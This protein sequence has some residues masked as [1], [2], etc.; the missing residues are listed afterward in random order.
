[1]KNKPISQIA[2]VIHDQS[3]VDNNNTNLVNVSVR[4]STKIA[5]MLELV[6]MIAG[7][8]ISTMFTDEISAKLADHVRSTSK[9]HNQIINALKEI[10]KER[11]FVPTGSA[12]D[13]LIKNGNLKIS[14]K[15]TKGFECFEGLEDYWYSYKR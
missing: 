3:L 4:P 2:Q 12:F 6:S 8:P 14:V 7:K 10:H 9:Y 1:M 5:A 15:S 11:E 13:I